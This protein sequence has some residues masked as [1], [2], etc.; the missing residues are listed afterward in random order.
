MQEWRILAQ[1]E[2]EHIHAG[3]SRLFRDYAGTNQEEF[4]AVAVEYFFE[5]S[6]QF[7]KELPELYKVMAGMLK[8]DPTLPPLR[9]IVFR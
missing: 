9:G 7:K 6:V 1:R 3:K 4:F 2:A 5:Q 8:Q